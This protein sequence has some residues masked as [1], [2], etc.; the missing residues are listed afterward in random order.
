VDCF[1]IKDPTSAIGLT[2]ILLSK[3][4]GGP[5]V[6]QEDL[7]IDEIYYSA[8]MTLT[9]LDVSATYSRVPTS[10]KPD[11]NLNLVFASIVP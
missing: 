1:C 6:P 9:L 3:V 7:S 2:P 4:W 11:G 8:R 10:A 5:V